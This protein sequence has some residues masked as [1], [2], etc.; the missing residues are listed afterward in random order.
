MGLISDVFSKVPP[1]RRDSFVQAIEPRLPNSHDSGG[2]ARYHASCRRIATRNMDELIGMCRMV[3]ADGA[4][5]DSEANFLLEWIQSNY[6]AINVWP[7]NLLYER[8]V[9][10]MVDG[11]IDPDEERELLE[12]LH[13][14][15]AGPPTQ[16]GPRVSGAVPFDDPA[17]LIKFDGRSFV[18]TGQFVYGPRRTVEQIITERGGAVAA[19]CSGKTNYL[20]VGTFGSEEWLHSTHGTKIIKAVELKQAGKPI[21]IVTERHWIDHL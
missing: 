18:M 20:V 10:A 2:P 4:V 7:G 1:D 14:V 21:A 13:K 12:I 8:I 3:L 5:D 11:T 19:S 17:P 6:L 15:A 16:D 9:S